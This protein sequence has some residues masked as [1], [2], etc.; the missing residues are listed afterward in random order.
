ML[1]ASLISTVI[2]T[3]LPGPG[4][5]YLSQTLKFLAPVRIGDTARAE[6]TIADMQRERRRLTLAAV[7][8]VGHRKVIEGDALIM[9]PERQGSAVAKPAA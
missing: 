6:V 1:T 2:G 9:I 4:C 8:R 5:I 3:K 7:C